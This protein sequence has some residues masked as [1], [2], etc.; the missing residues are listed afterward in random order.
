MS[1]T[2]LIWLTGLAVALTTNAQLTFGSNAE[3]DAAAQLYK[4]PAGVQ[5]RWAS[6]ENPQGRKG[7][8]ARDNKGAKGHAFDPIPS[9]A[10]HVLC[11]IKGSGTIRRIWMTLKA[12]NPH[13]LRAQRID[14][15]WDGQAKPAV[16]APVGDFFG[17]ILGQAAPFENALFSNPEGRSFVCTV[18]MPFRTGAKITV[19][20]ESEQDNTHIFYDVDYTLGDKHDDDTLYFHAHWR[21]ENPTALTEDFEIL[22]RVNGSGRF[23]GCH[24]GV[25]AN[26][27]NLGWWGEGEVK[28]YLDGDGLWP[29]LAGTGTED[30]IGTAWGQGEYAHQY[31]GCL[32]SH[33]EAQYYTFYR[34]HIPDPVYFD[35]NCRITI[36]QIGGSQRPNIV[37][38]LSEGVPI[39]PIS[40]NDSNGRFIRIYERGIDHAMDQASLP[41]GWINYYRQDDVCAVAFFYL[42]APV[43]TLPPLAP[44][45]ERTAD[46][47][48]LPGQ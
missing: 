26:P 48:T 10:T 23:L 40:C 43:N 31:Q 11:D 14:M 13:M 18:P 38:M 29:T 5:T 28:A 19:T 8:G 25:I 45:A 44:V 16:S 35:T 17:W 21:R 46:V 37:R 24:I 27:R 33:K 9:G 7:A 1:K 6:G 36:Q 3:N 2:S 12:K 22:P 15:Y 34:Y 47:K 42:D 20:N 30:Y 32:L 41:E 4:K 39:I